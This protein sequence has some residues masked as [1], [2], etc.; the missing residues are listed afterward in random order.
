ME[1]P[2]P[3]PILGTGG[4]AFLKVTLMSV[5]LDGQSN[6]SLTSGAGTLVPKR[7][8]AWRGEASPALKA[9][10]DT[11][12]GPA[13]KIPLMGRKLAVRFFGDDGEFRVQGKTSVAVVGGKEEDGP[14]S[15]I[16]TVACD[17]RE[18]DPDGALLQSLHLKVGTIVL[19]PPAPKEDQP[20]LGL[21]DPAAKNAPITIYAPGL[22]PSVTTRD[23]LDDDVGR[24]EFDLKEL[25]SGKAPKS[26]KP[27][28]K[29]KRRKGGQALPN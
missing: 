25:A 5:H 8:L 12:A 14:A 28:P 16:V 29:P 3:T 4:T 9:L 17:A 2:N 22:P 24:V 19:L 10:L 1:D 23:E 6:G 20:D 27:A 7:A 15:L 21:E 11:A 26:D 13:T 18:D